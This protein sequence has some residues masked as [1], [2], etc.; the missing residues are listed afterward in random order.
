[1]TKYTKYDVEAIMKCFD[2]KH[3]IENY[4]F[5]LNLARG[6]VLLELNQTQTK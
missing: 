3:F 1:M 4:C 2:V 5:A 6:K